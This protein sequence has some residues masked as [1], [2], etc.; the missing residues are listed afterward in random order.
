MTDLPA[1]PAAGRDINPHPGS[2]LREGGDLRVPVDA[3]PS[4]FNPCTSTAASPPPG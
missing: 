3:L 4:N 1:P 2:A